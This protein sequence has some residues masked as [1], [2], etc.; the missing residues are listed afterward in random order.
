MKIAKDNL[1]NQTFDFS[2]TISKSE[3]NAL[4]FE[5]R[6]WSSSKPVHIL[7]LVADVLSSPTSYKE[8]FALGG[9][10][11]IKPLKNVAKELKAKGEL[12]EFSYRL[13]QEN[14]AILDEINRSHTRH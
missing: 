7:A 5:G 10:I 14:V 11:G 6:F 9:I 2:Q 13:F 4:G 3:M 12:S 8:V 1:S